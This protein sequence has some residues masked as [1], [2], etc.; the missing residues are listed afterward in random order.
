MHMI[1]PPRY[2]YL[3]RW[4]SI[5]SP[6]VVSQIPAHLNYYYYTC[7]IRPRR[8]LSSGC[9]GRSFLLAQPTILYS[10]P[11]PVPSRPPHQTKTTSYGMDKRTARL[12]TSSSWYLNVLLCNRNAGS[13]KLRFLEYIFLFSYRDA[14]SNSPM[15][16]WLDGSLGASVSGYTWCF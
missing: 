6:V 8:C 1:L 16:G 3:D 4:L 12:S 9:G 2:A 10:S 7:W 15:P 14:F 5:L 11:Y 13:D